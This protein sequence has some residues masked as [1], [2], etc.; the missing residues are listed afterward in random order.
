MA[1]KTTIEK[2]ELYAEEHGIGILE[3]HELAFMWMMEHDHAHDLLI[4]LWEVAETNGPP[5]TLNP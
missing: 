1:E 4:R 3:M 2:L 5:P